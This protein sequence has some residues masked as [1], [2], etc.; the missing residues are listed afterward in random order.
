MMFGLSRRQLA[1]LLLYVAIMLVLPFFAGG[2]VL[3]VLIVFLLAAYVGQT[4]NIMMGFVGQLSLGHALYYG[5]GAYTAAALY[6]H[7]ALLPWL[8][9]LAGMA[10][11]GLAGAAIAALSFRFGVAGVYFALLTIAFNEFTHILFDHFTWVGA[12]AGL[13]LPVTTISHE[14]LAHLRGSPAMFYY[15]LLALSLGVLG[16][17]RELLR[18]RVG[19]YWQAIREDPHAAASLGID[20]FRYRLGAMTL[21]ASLTATAGAVMAFYDANLYPDTIFTTARSVEII[22]GPIIGGIGTLAGPIVGAF[23]LTLLGE[24]MTQV[25]SVLGIAGLKQLCYGGALVFIVLLQ[26]SGLWPWLRRVLGLADR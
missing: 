13:F 18:R 12:T 24:G 19:Y 26:P 2:Y 9:M 11:A 6:V 10:L 21:S 4:W 14:D 16:L 15:L 3:S 1:A 7:F 22:T 5:L 23:V 8:G 20:V 25:N 17:S